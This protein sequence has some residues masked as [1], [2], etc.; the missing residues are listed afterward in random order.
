MVNVHVII[1]ESSH[2]SGP[3][4]HRQIGRSAQ[5]FESKFVEIQSLF[6][7]TRKLILEN[8]EMLN[9]NS[10]GSENPSRARSTLLNDQ[11]TKWTKARVRLYSDA[12]LCMGRI[13]DSE[14][15][16]RKWQG[17]AAEFRMENS[18]GE[19][20]G[21]DGEP[22]E[23]EWVC[24]DDIKMAAEK[25]N[26]APMWKKLMKNVDFDE[27]ASFLDHFHLGCTQREC[28]PNDT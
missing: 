19:L 16:N 23:F 9:V 13:H 21:Q 24:V 12:V 2:P 27:P 7:V 4:L 18:F 1:D 15:A 6:D 8:Q 10:T 28:K 22:I 26:M 17:Q 14:E 11:A 5:E 20:L 3:K 25:Q